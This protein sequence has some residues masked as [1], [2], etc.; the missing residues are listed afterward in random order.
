[1]GTGEGTS[2]ATPCFKF[3]I[4]KLLKKYF[5]YNEEES[6]GLEKPTSPG[7][8]LKMQISF[9]DRAV[10]EILEDVSF[11]LAKVYKAHG[12]QPK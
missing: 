11:K 5:L 12:I 9:Y 4:T 2:D 6:T 8:M 3:D 7:D 1:M 10:D